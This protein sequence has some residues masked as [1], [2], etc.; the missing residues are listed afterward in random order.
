MSLNKHS[1]KTHD[2]STGC[3][4]HNS[5]LI[6]SRCPVWNSVAI[7]TEVL[8]GF[9]QS[10][11][12]IAVKLPRFGPDRVCLNP[13]QF[14]THQLFYHRRYKELWSYCQSSSTNN[15]HIK[16]SR[17]LNKGCRAVKMLKF[18]S[19]WKKNFRKNTQLSIFIKIRPVQ[20]ELF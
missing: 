7:L 3:K 4:R 19:N 16:W 10:L 2:T 13:S 18:L 5:V 1:M 15:T 6:L 14:V 20:V 11:H 9:P 12:P 17:E 8:P